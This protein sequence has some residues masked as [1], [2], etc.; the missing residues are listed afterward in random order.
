MRA[1]GS[2]EGNWDAIT[3]SIVSP[4]RIGPSAA[5]WIGHREV[6]V[7]DAMKREAHL[8]HRG[9]HAP[10]QVHRGVGEDEGAIAIP[11]H[12]RR[13]GREALDAV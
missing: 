10:S 9:A 13:G 4:S 11:L 8:H 1:S 7:Q 5:R 2:I 3:R 6:H 12:E